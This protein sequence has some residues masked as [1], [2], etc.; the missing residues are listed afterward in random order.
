MGGEPVKIH[1]REVVDADLPVLFEH[2][3]DPVAVRMAAFPSRDRDAF[4]AHW[5]KLRADATN[6]A[7]AI[8]VDGRLAGHIGSFVRD[9]VREVG[10]WIGREFW[11][12]GVASAALAAFLR[13]DKTR[14]L[15][16]GVVRDNAGSIRVLE[17]C[18]FS[19]VRRETEFSGVRG[20]EIELLILR[21]D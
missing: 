1:L 3:R 21:L 6:L 10:Y 4:M 14:P 8:E 9:G 16:A 17:K 11:G 2:Q 15:C 5:A 7:R 13:I 18:G 19:I 20:A 12:R